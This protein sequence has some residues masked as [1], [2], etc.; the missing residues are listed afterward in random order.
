MRTRLCW[1]VAG[2]FS[3]AAADS[4]L[5]LAQDPAPRQG[6]AARSNK[7][8]VGS[9]RITGAWTGTWGTYQPGDEG[10]KP[11][12]PDQPRRLDCQVVAQ[13]GGAWQATFEGECGRPYKY[14]I[15]LVGRQVGDVALF[16]GTVD[17]GEKDGG[18][19]DWIGRANEHEFIGFYTSQRYTGVFRLARPK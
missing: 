9:P 19:Y 8:A 11:S 17:L 3:L 10:K 6:E 18:V 5:S 15:Q 4:P 7:A 13:P 16:K 2:V 14:T 1:L 12:Q